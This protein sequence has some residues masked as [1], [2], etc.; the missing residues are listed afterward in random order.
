MQAGEGKGGLYRLSEPILGRYAGRFAGWSVRVLVGCAL[1][2][3]EAAS[4]TPI[5]RVHKS[6]TRVDFFILGS[7]YFTFPYYIRSYFEDK[8]AAKDNHKS[9]RTEFRK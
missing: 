2:L 7:V 8:L 9:G 3:D 6:T 1:I 4:A 5:C